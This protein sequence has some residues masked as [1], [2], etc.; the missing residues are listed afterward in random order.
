MGKSRRIIFDRRVK[1]RVGIVP[2]LGNAAAI[3]GGI[4]VIRF[5]R[6]AS[7]APG[8]LGSALMFAKQ[9]S[10][11]LAKN[12]NLKLGV[13]M[14]VGGNPHRVAW[15]AEYSGL[16]AM[17]ESQTKFM[18]DPKYLELLS[19]GGDNFIAGSLTDSIWRTV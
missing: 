14:P 19:T 6:I 1:F 9:I 18:A 4:I 3:M 13:M 11:Y 5:V 7:I 8:K 15:R 10:E 16:A 2:A 12:H 17:E